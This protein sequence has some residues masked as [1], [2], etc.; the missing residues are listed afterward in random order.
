M[1]STDHP[2][3]GALPD[4]AVDQYEVQHDVMVAELREAVRSDEERVR[5]LAERAIG[6]GSQIAALQGRLAATLAELDAAGGCAGHRSAGSWAG[7]HLGLPTGEAR[8]LAKVAGALADRPVLAAACEE[9]SIPL[10]AAAMVADVTTPD[11]EA[12]VVAL[13]R[14]ATGPQVTKICADVRHATRDDTADPPEPHV[15]VTKD[16]GGY[17][18]GGWLPALGGD[19]VKQGLQAELDRLWD[20]HRTDGNLVPTRVDALVGLAE[21]AL[22]PDAMTVDRAE[23]YLTMI[24]VDLDGQVTLSDDT[25]IDLDDFKRILGDSSF[26][27]LVSLRGTPLW[28]TRKTR[29][30]NRAMRRALRARD[31]HCAYPGCT[32]LGY[33]EA[34]HLTPF[35]ERPETRVDGLVLLCWIHHHIVHQRNETLTRAPDGAIT[36]HRADG[37]VWTGTRPPPEPADPPDIRAH[38]RAYAGE[39]LTHDARDVILHHLLGDRPVPTPS[40]SQPTDTDTDP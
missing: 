12:R 9:G 33:L 30:A 29:T 4:G 32:N 37:S 31:R 21:R 10:A 36:V 8:R 2:Q 1:T 18:L 22:D 40:A 24:H 7:W 19:R 17:R 23:K 28:T 26:S 38:H 11:N 35:A 20:R 39:R 25:P 5:V 14:D 16:R 6:L 3:P 27:W 13:A 34:H 15:S